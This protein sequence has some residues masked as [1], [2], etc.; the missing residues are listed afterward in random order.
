M[1]IT[2]SI[3]S[4]P[5]IWI[6][7]AFF[8]IL[9]CLD[10]E[11]CWFLIPC[12]SEQTA[13][14]WNRI[15]LTLSYSYISAVIFHVIVNYLPYK[16]KQKTMAPYI[17]RK[18]KQL[19]DLL[20]QAKLSVISPFDFNRDESNYNR[21]RYVELFSKTNLTEGAFFD[22]GKKKTTYLQEIRENVDYTID[23]LLTYR[24]LLTDDQLSFINHIAKSPFITQKL[25]ANDEEGCPEEY[26]NQKEI[27]ECIYDIYG[28]VKRMIK[29]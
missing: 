25:Y 19:K 3:L 24:D 13:E 26:K 4:K 17:Q 15:I 18:M 27:G 28:E 22:S 9:L 5:Y 12:S 1:N 8:S 6:T 20:H 7:L 14:I 11:F 16:V 10:I 21:E 23:Q 29:N 2:L